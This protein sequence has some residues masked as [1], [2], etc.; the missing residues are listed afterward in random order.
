MFSMFAQAENCV[1]VA[2]VNV[3]YWGVVVLVG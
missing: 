2:L 3:S 1:V